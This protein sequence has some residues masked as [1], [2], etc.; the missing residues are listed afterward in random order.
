MKE[1]RSRLLQEIESVR[2]IR[3][4][5]DEIEESWKI[6][7][8]DEVDKKVEYRTY[9]FNKM[10]K[11]FFEK[12]NDDCSSLFIDYCEHKL[13]LYEIRRCVSVERCQF[14]ERIHDQEYSTIAASFDL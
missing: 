1:N 8:R 10:L 12:M 9:I 3:V 4:D 13:N 6:R 14:E 7:I 2:L 11:I 5:T